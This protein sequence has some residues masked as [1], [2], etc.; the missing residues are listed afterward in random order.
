MQDLQTRAILK[1]NFEGKSECIAYTPC[2]GLE[3][4]GVNNFPESQGIYLL[5]LFTKYFN[6]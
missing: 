5:T 3:E 2:G 4:R 1:M 6:V